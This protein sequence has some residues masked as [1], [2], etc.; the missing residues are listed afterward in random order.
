MNKF[1]NM[2]KVSKVT[3]IACAYMCMNIVTTWPRDL[4]KHFFM[5]VNHSLYTMHET[6][7]T[8]HELFRQVA[9]W[10]SITLLIRWLGVMKLQTPPA[11]LATIAYIVTSPAVWVL[12][13]HD[14]AQ[15]LFFWIYLC[16]SDTSSDCI[17]QCIF[18]IIYTMCFLIP[19]N[20]FGCPVVYHDFND[21]TFRMKCSAG[22]KTLVK[23][24]DSLFFRTP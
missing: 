14:V 18:W 9:P 10:R 2:L 1:Y 6:S 20:C 12:S 21:N 8:C 22:L 7:W 3:V 16:I 4:G 11:W 15:M 5:L 17:T 13:L 19:I 24:C 23:K